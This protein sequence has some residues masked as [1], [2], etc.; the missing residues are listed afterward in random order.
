M[1]HVY[2]ALAEK[3]RRMISYELRLIASLVWWIPVRDGCD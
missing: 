1:L 2:A 3:E